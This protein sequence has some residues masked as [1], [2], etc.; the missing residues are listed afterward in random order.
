VSLWSSKPAPNLLEG[1]D[2]KPLTP[3][4]VDKIL[5]AKIDEALIAP[6]KTP[7]NPK[8]LDFVVD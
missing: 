6:F 2:I 4:E 1:M 8:V 7:F 5:N 3:E